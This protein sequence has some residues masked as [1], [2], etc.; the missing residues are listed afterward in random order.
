MKKMDDEELQKWMEENKLLNKETN[1]L[2]SDDAKAYQFLFDALEQEPL[3]SLPY[4]FS[5]KVTRKVQADMKRN[6]ELRSYIISLLAFLVVIAIMFGFSIFIKPGGGPSYISV[7]LEYK[8]A[9]ILTVFS[10]TTIQYL[11]QILVKANIFKR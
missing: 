9:I 5:A 10:F 8:W 4:D 11:D 7:M 2:I 6:S 1:G 3:Q